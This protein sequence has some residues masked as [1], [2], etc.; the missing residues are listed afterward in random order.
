MLSSKF[1]PDENFF[2]I[3]DHAFFHKIVNENVPISLPDYIEPYTGQGRLQQANLLILLVMYVLSLLV[4]IHRVDLL[5]ICHSS[6]E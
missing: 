3:N 2:D 1:N 6:T 4:R 5:F